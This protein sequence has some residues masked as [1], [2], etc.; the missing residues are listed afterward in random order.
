MRTVKEVAR[1]TGISIRT[2]QYYDE[3]GVF[4]PTEV[5]EVGYRLYDDHALEKLQQILFFK[6][7]DFP[8]KDIKE[9]ME[10]PNYNKLEVFKKQKNILR[11]KRD[12]LN[13]LLNLIEE[14]E[15]GESNMS[16]KEFDMSEY[17]EALE[18]FKIKNTEEVIKYWGNIDKFNEFIEKVKKDE[19]SGAEMAIKQFGSVQKYTE[20]MKF[21]L[22]H[23]SELMDKINKQ[24]ENKEEILEK[25]EEL[26]RRLTADLS[27]E[28]SSEEIQKV[29]QEI[30]E[31]TNETSSGI[32]L[33]EGYWDTVIEVYKKEEIRK[34][35]D[36]KYGEGATDYIARALK[37]YFG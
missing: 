36:K 33:G 24:Q 4:E 37:Y 17:I 9:I 23:F 8:L 27:K 32:N 31:F 12:R 2:L 21:N 14:L 16:F 13:R 6:E 1:L 28:V 3:I 7:L 30:I 15:R 18:A 19:S 20:A 5:N 34:C 35:N 10:T 26:F 25:N 29:V 22:E 11:V